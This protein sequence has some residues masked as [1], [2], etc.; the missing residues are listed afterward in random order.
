MGPN[1][2]P[3]AGLWLWTEP[4]GGSC[5]CISSVF[6][7]SLTRNITCLLTTADK[8]LDTAQWD[9]RLGHRKDV[10]SSANLPGN[11]ARKEFDVY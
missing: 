9:P 8:T 10:P 11:D 3:E 1:E 6:L 2:L 7:P 4:V 5:A